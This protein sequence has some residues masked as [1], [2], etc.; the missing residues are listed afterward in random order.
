MRDI[1]GCKCIEFHFRKSS[2]FQLVCR[3][4]LVEEVFR[5]YLF[6]KSERSLYTINIQYRI[7]ASTKVFFRK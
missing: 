3:D 4:F 1:L 7:F 5:S 2:D 6:H